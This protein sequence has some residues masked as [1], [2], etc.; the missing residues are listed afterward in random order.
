M[1]DRNVTR[2]AASLAFLVLTACSVHEVTTMEEWCQQISG[3]DLIE[4]NAPF[5]AIF[6]GVTFKADAIRDDFVAFLNRALLEKVENRTPKMAWRDANDLH[7]KNLSTYFEIEP[8]T[9]I[10]EWRANIELSKTFKDP[11]DAHRCFYGTI[12]SLFDSVNIHSGTWDPPGFHLV[13]DDV[14]TI[15]TERHQRLKDPL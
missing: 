9:V 7:V 1:G 14:T 8:E 5:W 10:E 4:K 3:V 15:D 6:P 11:D 12:T 2:V 13:R